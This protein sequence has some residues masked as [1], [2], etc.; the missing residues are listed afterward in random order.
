[1]KYAMTTIATMLMASA[2]LGAG[3]FESIPFNQPTFSDD[4][5][6]GVSAITTAQ[7]TATEAKSTATEAKQKATAL[8]TIIAETVQKGQLTNDL[9]VVGNAK[10]GAALETSTTSMVF[11]INRDMDDMQTANGEMLFSSDKVRFDVGLT[12]FWIGSDNLAT[13]LSSAGQ[14]EVNTIVNVKTNG[15]ALIPDS[16][17]AIDIIIPEPKEISLDG[18]LDETNGVAFGDFKVYP[19]PSGTVGQTHT[20]ITHE[21]MSIGDVEYKEDEIT[22]DG[23]T[24]GF[25]DGPNGI[26]RLKDLDSYKND[27]TIRGA[28]TPANGGRIYIDGNECG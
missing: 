28:P 11:A 23:D 12:G 1:M 4:D 27:L 9:V 14:G 7:N 24:Y 8:E 26:A 10:N 2:M 6:L 21:S 13:I 5:P 15:V 25:D 17:R 22:H 18:K 16:N 3:T 19:M 20:I